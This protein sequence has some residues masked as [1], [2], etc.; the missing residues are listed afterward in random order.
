MFVLKRRKLIWTRSPAWRPR[1]AQI[2]DAIRKILMDATVIDAADLDATDIVAFVRTVPI[3]HTLFLSESVLDMPT[4]TP[5][6]LACV[7]KPC[8]GTR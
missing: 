2:V 5:A 6:N 7:S 8:G 1:A 3:F 4:T